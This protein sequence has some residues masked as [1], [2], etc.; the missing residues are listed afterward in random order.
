MWGKKEGE[1][2]EQNRKKEEMK[3]QRR[4][5]SALLNIT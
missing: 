4:E 5:P 2:E 3:H 1:D